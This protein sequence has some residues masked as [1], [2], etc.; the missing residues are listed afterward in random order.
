MTKNTEAL[1]DLSKLI[2]PTEIDNKISKEIVLSKNTPWN[3]IIDFANMRLLIPTLYSALE[4]KGLLEHI[5][6]ELIVE[7][8]T[9]V[10][11][12]NRIRNEAIMLQL[13]DISNLL[14][15]IGVT[16][17]L[18]KGAAALSERY[19]YHIGAR[20]MM[21]VDILVP[22]EKIVKCIELMETKGGYKTFENSSSEWGIHH[23]QRIS[24]DNGVAAV[25]LHFRSLSKAYSYFPNEEFMQHIRPS[26]TIENADVL[27]P[28][29]DMYHVFLHSEISD[30]SHRNHVLSLKNVHHAA[31]IA[32][33][34]ESEI[35]WDLLAKKVEKYSISG[36][37]ADYLYKMNTLFEIKV[38][39]HMLGTSKHF[40]KII[41]NIDN[42]RRKSKIV[43][44]YFKI[45]DE[46][47]Y[48]IIKLKYNLKSKL[49]Y[50]LA[51]IKYICYLFAKNTFSPK[52]QKLLL[53]YCEPRNPSQKN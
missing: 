26:K 3:E 12:F 27:E 16:P 49:E 18:L 4:H 47:S 41:Y 30:R 36:I 46:L 25:E 19:Y 32:T 34:C 9:T 15:E 48:S 45:K 53:K 33:A 44:F 5:E 40:R 23:Y 50:P 29:Y 20:V 35:D 39:S 13:Q 28:T 1:L 11:E 7:Y 52:N 51:L 17:V 38:P 2:S 31:V 22:E 21:D 24:S 42:N 6:D 8:L 10:Y 43:L 37:W 14:S